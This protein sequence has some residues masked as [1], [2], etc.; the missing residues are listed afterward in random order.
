MSSSALAM[1][2]DILGWKESLQFGKSG[3]FRV[4]E[5]ENLILER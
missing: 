2:P 5:M 1:I 3:A 4:S